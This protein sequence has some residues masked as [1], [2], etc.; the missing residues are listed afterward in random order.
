MPLSSALLP[1]L[2][3]LGLVR[4]IAILFVSVIFMMS[5]LCKVSKSFHPDTYIMLD[6]AYRSQLIPAWQSNV[7]DKYK[8]PLHLDAHNIKVCVGYIEIAST[9]V[10]WCFGTK[11]AGYVMALLMVL[12]TISHKMINEDSAFPAV[13]AVLCMFLA[14]T[15]KSG[16]RP[17][18]PVVATARAPTDDKSK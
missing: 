8:V 17:G 1:G 12:V 11:F 14:L 7:F 15:T 6:E 4:S 5:G 18:A 16:R 13:I 3:M 2:A 9:I 10:M